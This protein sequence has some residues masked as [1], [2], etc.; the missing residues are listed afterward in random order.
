MEEK[1]VATLYMMIDEFNLLCDSFVARYYFEIFGYS[2]IH[3]LI[4]ET[5]KS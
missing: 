5:T 1:V 3:I 2:N 4:K